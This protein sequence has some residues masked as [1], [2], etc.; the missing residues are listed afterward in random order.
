MAYILDSRVRNLFI[1]LLAFGSAMTVR[2]DLVSSATLSSGLSVDLEIGLTASSGGDLQWTGSSLVPQGSTTVSLQGLI[3][4]LVYS[5][6][7]Q[8]NDQAAANYSSA[9]LA[10]NVL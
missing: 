3:G 8:A 4:T 9:A 7:T 6:F 1:A 10:G 5:G 2:A